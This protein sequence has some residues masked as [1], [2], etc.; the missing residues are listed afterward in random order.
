LIASDRDVLKVAEL[1][2]TVVVFGSGGV[3][4]LRCGQV[5]AGWSAVAP[6]G[7]LVRSSWCGSG[8]LMSLVQTERWMYRPPGSYSWVGNHV[9]SPGVWRCLCLHLL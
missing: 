2:W 3:G 5:M 9:E 8:Q 7:W 6:A 4:W 1:A